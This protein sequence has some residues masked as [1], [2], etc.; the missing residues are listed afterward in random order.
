MTIAPN[1]SIGS[2]ARR[3]AAAA[4][5]SSRSDKAMRSFRLIPD[6]TRIQFVRYRYWAY[7]FSGALVLLT[8]ILLPTKG[9]NFGIDFQG[10]ILIE[11]GMPGAAPISRRCAATLGRP[12]PGRGRAP[13]VRRSRERADP[14]RAPGGRRG[15]AARCGRTRSRPR[16]PSASATTSATGG[17]SS[18]ARRSARIC[19]GP[20]LRRPSTPSSPSSPTSGSGSNGSSRSAPSWR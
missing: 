5:A 4:Q 18:S 8:L 6:D 17:S 13:G 16:S 15:R 1:S 9:L 11:V 14:D 20:A 2:R 19:S 10:G 7:A 12:G 3:S